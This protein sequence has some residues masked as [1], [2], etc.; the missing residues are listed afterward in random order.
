VPSEIATLS[1]EESEPTMSSQEFAY[2]LYLFRAA[3]GAA[4][5]IVPWQG[6]TPE[7]VAADPAQHSRRFYESILRG[8]FSG[9]SVDKWFSEDLGEAELLIRKINKES[10]LII[11]WDATIMTAL[12]LA[13]ILAGGEV[14]LAKGRFKLKSLGHA[15]K[16]LREALSPGFGKSTSHTPSSQH[17]HKK[18]Q[19]TKR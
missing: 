10:P 4:L 3:Y 8:S 16:E 11:W 5:Q 7:M 2:F 12:V 9:D 19:S 15:I 14:D 18:G 6:I 1:F 17:S 13:V